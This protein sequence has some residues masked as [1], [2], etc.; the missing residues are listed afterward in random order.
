MKVTAAKGRPM[1]TWVGKRPLSHVTAF[2]AQHVETFD[3]TGQLTPSR[4][5]EM[6]SDW[7]AAY[8]KG[9][10]LFHG[11]NLEVLAH[12]L[13]NGFRGQVDL[14]YIDPP[15]DSGAD[16]VRRVSLRGRKEA[17]KLEG[18]G[19]TLGEQI[20]YTD[21]WANDNYLQFMYERLL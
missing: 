14:I 4:T 18:E 20:Q 1:L 11:D 17:A 3:P 8:P 13:A 9:G 15:F 16:Y 10:L 5:E 12:L 6:W 19:Y 2:P 21:I 7:P